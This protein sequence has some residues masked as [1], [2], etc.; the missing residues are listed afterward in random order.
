MPD[1][2]CDIAIIGGGPAASAAAWTLRQRAPQLS[3]TIV[4]SGNHSKPR[5]GETL[6]PTAQSVLTQMGLWDS[7]LEQGH[8]PAYGTS[9]GR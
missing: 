7:F 6:P 9:A 3:V 4:E 5:V 2:T 8:L 1:Q